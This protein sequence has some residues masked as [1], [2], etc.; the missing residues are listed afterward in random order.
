MPIEY[1][2]PINPYVNR[3]S[4]EVAKLLSNRFANNLMYSNELEEQLANLQVAD[5]QGDMAAK[6]ALEQQ[7]KKTLDGLATRGDYENLTVPI[8]RA[9]QDFTEQ[10]APLQQNYKLYEE[11]KKMEQERIIRGD[12]T[13]DQYDNW[14]RR[15]KYTNNPTTGDLGVYSGVRRREDGNVDPSSFFQ[16]VPIARAVNVDEE[17][18]KMI[19]TL[20]PE[21]RGGRSATS[22]QTG[23][24][25]IRYVVDSEGEIIE[26]ITPDRVAAVTRQV[27]DRSDVRSYLEQ[28]A[29]FNTFEA[30]PEELQMMLRQRQSQ[31]RGKASH[32]NHVREIGAALN[33]GSTGQMRAMARKILQDQEAERYMDMA[34]KAGAT[35]SRYGGGFRSRI[36]SDYYS[37][38]RDT[39]PA[40]QPTTPVITGEPQKV[41]SAAVKNGSV[42]PG[43]VVT[44]KTDG[45]AQIK[46][47][48]AIFAQKHPD[49]WRVT[50]PDIKTYSD[51]RIIA[52]YGKYGKEAV[53]DLIAFKN[54]QRQV[55]VKLE[56]LDQLE[57]QAKQQSGYTL[58]NAVK[59]VLI[60]TAIDN[61]IQA[62]ELGDQIISTISSRYNVN[63]EDAIRM[64]AENFLS[65]AQSQ[66]QPEMNNTG[67]FPTSSPTSN[68][69]VLRALDAQTN[70]SSREA[71]SIVLQDVFDLDSAQATKIANTT[72]PKNHNLDTSSSLSYNNISRTYGGLRD[73][74]EELL[75]NSAQSEIAFNVSES[76]FGD[77]SKDKAVSSTLVKTL[78]SSAPESFSGL[79]DRVTG[80]PVSEILGGGA[81]TID[82]V[83]FT[84]AIL[85]DYTIASNAVQMTFKPASG[86]EGGN[87]VVILPYEEVVSEYNVNTS[88][89]PIDANAITLQQYPNRI[90]SEVYTHKI[91]NPLAPSVT[92][93]RDFSSGNLS[94]EFIFED[95]EKGGV[96]FPQIV[97]VTSTY[98][99]INGRRNENTLSLQ[100][101]MDSYL[102]N[103]TIGVF[104]E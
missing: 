57:A 48:A 21:K 63:Q 89:G 28:E 77:G 65:G 39:T 56:A 75:N 74:Y 61:G 49:V 60:E 81:Y 20:D 29:D 80:E 93:N 30:S 26:Q 82:D 55:G 100:D 43:S 91:N 94:A 96:K 3:G 35:T 58:Q 8:V 14:L 22:F 6:F 59:A 7:T 45:A 68:V 104:E 46:A 2:T 83:K 52:E 70:K 69:G 50:P 12:I 101:W 54:L 102:D 92:I 62:S 90:L 5:F 11:A 103:L 25:G 40:P 76:M 95:S 27:L 31:L 71:L 37:Y 73:G 19:N 18:I 16:H 34:I 38:L 97:G 44:A 78:K 24:D 79:T 36:D 99:D 23:A 53:Q 67:Y 85:P 64:Y 33:S 1:G 13:K 72:Q 98:T 42:T 87:K 4:V 51:Q 88:A 66:A 32:A 15:S 47:Q 86:T 9:S 41:S 84:H 17:I 10:Y